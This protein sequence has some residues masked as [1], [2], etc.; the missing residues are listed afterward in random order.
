MLAIL[1]VVFFLDNIKKEDEKK[2][3]ISVE[4]LIATFKLNRDRKQLLLLPLTTYVGMSPAFLM[5]E[6]TKVSQTYILTLMLLVA[7]LANTK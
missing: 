3:G 2:K 6:F 1:C 4:L 5:A 7:T